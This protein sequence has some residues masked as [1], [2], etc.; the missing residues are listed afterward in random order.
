MSLYPAAWVLNYLVQFNQITIPK[1]G[2]EAE[3]AMRGGGNYLL[4]LL[5]LHNPLLC[6]FR[7][8]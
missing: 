6:V 3:L 7:L 2:R 4:P 1:P 5:G 8:Y